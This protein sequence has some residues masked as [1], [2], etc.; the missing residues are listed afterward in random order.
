VLA[1]L[2]AVLPAVAAGGHRPAETSVPVSLLVSRADGAKGAAAEA[3]SLEAISAGAGRIVFS[4]TPLDAD[5]KGGLYLRDVRRQTTT[6]LSSRGGDAALSA[7]A[8]VLALSGEGILIRRL[9]GG[10]DRRAAP[11]GSGEPSLSAD[12]DVLAFSS[13]ASGLA[14]PNEDQVFVRDLEKGRAI[15]VS[16]ATGGHGALADGESN[17]PVI[18]ADGRI[19]AFVSHARNL[20][21]KPEGGYVSAVYLRDLSTDRTVRV[22]PR[23]TLAGEPSISGDGS[24]ITFASRGSIYVF[25]RHAGTGAVVASSG[26]D[27]PDLGP[28]LSADGRYVAYRA[29]VSNRGIKELAITDVRTRRTVRIAK[30]GLPE[31]DSGPIALSANGRFITYDTHTEGLVDP[32]K[33]FQES[34]RVYRARNPLF[35]SQK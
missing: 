1:L 35:Q 4:S 29:G 12:G 22:S 23:G 26:R 5:A 32:E 9:P 10:K 2:L 19:V 17:H 13:S 8:S 28:S 3:A 27:T 15:Q 6:R 33:N 25:D 11:S 14:P 34:G 20:A 7:D 18:S 21:G 31:G 16:R 30:V 24:R